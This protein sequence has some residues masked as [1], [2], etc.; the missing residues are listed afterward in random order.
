MTAK[1]PKPTILEGRFVRLEPLSPTH[2]SGL[3]TAIAHRSVFE[4]GFGG[5]LV[6]LPETFPAFERWAN[7]YLNLGR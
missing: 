7:D 3:Y 2:L 5:G 1:R 6:D 4:F